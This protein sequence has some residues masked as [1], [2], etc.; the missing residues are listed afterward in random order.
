[1][2]CCAWAWAAMVAHVILECHVSGQQSRWLWFV[3]GLIVAGGV[4]S[5]HNMALFVPSLGLFLL[6]SKQHRALLG[7]SGFWIMSGI[8]AVVGGGPIVGWN[9]QN[10]WV[11]FLHVGTQ[12]GVQ[13]GDAGIRWVGPLEFLGTQAGLLLGFWF[14]PMVMGLVQVGRDWLHRR[15]EW[16][17]LFLCCLAL[18]ILLICLAFSFKVRIE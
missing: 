15:V 7:R 14:L 2:Y 6:L 10:D 13:S 4:L 12:A 5:K 8:V 18:P 3:L 11:T 16:N 17:Q 1:P 9:S